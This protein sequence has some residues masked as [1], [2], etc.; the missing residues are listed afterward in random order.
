M[1][2]ILSFIFSILLFSN[3]S[4][5][6][7]TAT[8]TGYQQIYN[9]ISAVNDNVVWTGG[10]FGGVAR[11]INGGSSWSISVVG[12]SLNII[13][14]YGIDENN[15]I[16]I[17]DEFVPNRSM[18]WKTSNGGNTWTQVYE[19][20]E[21]LRVLEISSSGTGLCIGDAVGGRWS[22]LKTTDFGTSWDTTGMFLAGTGEAFDNCMYFDGTGY[23]FGASGGRLF[24]TTNTGASWSVDTIGS[25]TVTSVWFNGLSGFLVS[26]KKYRST[27]GGLTWDSVSHPAIG[28]QTPTV[29]IG[30]M[31]W[32]ISRGSIFIYTSTDNGI[33]WNTSNTPESKIDIAI[34]RTGGTI[35]IATFGDRILHN[36]TGVNINTISNQIPVGFSLSQNYPNPFNPSTKIK[37]AIPNSSFVKLAVYDILGR[38]AAVLVDEQLSPG[39]YEYNFNAAELTSGTYFYR[40]STETFSQTRKML[41]VK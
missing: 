11:T 17:T 38:E 6:Q 9:S 21:D 33:T 36:S 22:I 41:L 35:W 30:N 25:S 3:T 4:H 39:S 10:H 23:W 19:Q 12:D 2:P 29:G 16:V 37:F 34:S 32:Q 8:P 24:H 7:W 5:S 26:D 40:I 18:I 15:A 27:D 20:S 28:F 14:I 13:N 31:M 1:K